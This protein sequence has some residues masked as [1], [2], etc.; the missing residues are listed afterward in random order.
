MG[1]GF[2]VILGLIV[3]T[4]PSLAATAPRR[5]WWARR[6]WR[7]SYGL[8]LV[9]LA[10]PFVLVLVLFLIAS[11]FDAIREMGAFFWGGQFEW[12][13]GLVLGWLPGS[14]LLAWLDRHAP[15]LQGPPLSEQ[16]AA[17]AR[18]PEQQW[19]AVRQYQRETGVD[20]AVATDVVEAYLAGRPGGALP[21]PRPEQPLGWMYGGFAAAWYGALGACY[22]L[23][24]RGNSNPVLSALALFLFIPALFGGFCGICQDLVTA[25][26]KE[27]LQAALASGTLTRRYAFLA[28]LL[29]GGASIAGVLAIGLGAYSFWDTEAGVLA[30]L[31]GVAAVLAAAPFLGLGLLKKGPVTRRPADV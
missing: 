5:A 7:L 23:T 12:L 30:G 29:S 6:W 27:A 20:T 26:T 18:D 4:G 19:Q 31:F 3:G 10:L 17:L 2:W 15:R 1:F 21:E 13:T 8:A 22:V 11:A 24:L 28:G 25:Q 16:P 14:G 9:C